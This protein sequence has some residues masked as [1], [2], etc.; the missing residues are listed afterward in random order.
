MRT[1][2]PYRFPPLT[3]ALRRAASPPPASGDADAPLC[4]GFDEGFR[5][6]MER[7]YH[8]GFERGEADGRVQGRDAGRD[9]G[10]QEACAAVEVRFA[11]LAQTIDT[12]L[13]GLH[14]VQDDYQTAR[15]TELVELVAKVAKQVVRCELALQPAQLLSLIDETLGAMPA[16]VDAPQIYLN[17]DEQA[18]LVELLPEH[19]QRWTLL[20]DARLEPGECRVR[21]GDH[22]ADAGCRHRLD[23]CVEQVRAQL[24]GAPDGGDAAGAAPASEPDA[25]GSVA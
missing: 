19:A 6:G 1:Y 15:R 9:A 17:P 16:A 8:A 2:L 25:S 4:T 11:G 12:M 18:R 14:R 3:V 10:T 7:G 22:E 13:E 5:Q 24:L 21:L 20:A 23:A